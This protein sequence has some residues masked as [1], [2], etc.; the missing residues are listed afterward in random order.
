MKI[1]I[2]QELLS[3]QFHDIE[4]GEKYTIYN[5]FTNTETIYEATILP[6][7]LKKYIT[8][9]CDKLC[10]SFRD[11]IKPTCL[12]ILPNC[13]NSIGISNTRIKLLIPISTKIEHTFSNYKKVSDYQLFYERDNNFYKKKLPTGDYL[14]Y[15]LKGN[16]NN[17]KRL[18]FTFPHFSENPLT[19]KVNSYHGFSDA[20]ND[21]VIGLVDKYF[22]NGSFLLFDN[23][24]NSLEY[25]VIDF[26]QKFINEYKDCYSQIIFIGMN[27]GATI[28][29][30]YES[31]FDIDKVILYDQPQDINQL[32]E[33]KFQTNNYEFFNY[34]SILSTSNKL[35]ILSNNNTKNTISEFSSTSIIKNNE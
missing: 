23:F 11:G 5:S 16:I 28:A 10:Y 7:T 31:F 30:Y 24:G 12:V 4:I 34:K 27:K 22:S 19:F 6:P 32:L 21:L 14:Y 35:S 20:N 15:I 18:I 1:L 13:I 33:D 3:L 25:F 29:K 17:P 26:I 8:I 9:Q 2:E